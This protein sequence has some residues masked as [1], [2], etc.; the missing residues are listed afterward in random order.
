MS[1]PTCGRPGS[2]CE[3]YGCPLGRL[4]DRPSRADRLR[5]PPAPG[6][7]GPVSDWPYP[8][9][10]ESSLDRTWDREVRP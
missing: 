6:S 9:G 2:T 5:H 4:Y 10:D 8:D 1:C 7:D 3:L